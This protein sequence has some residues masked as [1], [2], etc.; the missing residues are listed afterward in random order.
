MHP[1]SSRIAI[2]GGTGKAGR[3]VVDAALARGLEVRSLARRPVV[4][5]PA[6]PGLETLAGDARDRAVIGSLIEGCG[7]VVL[8]LASRRGEEPGFEAAARS[9]VAAMEAGYVARCVVL[10]GLGIDVPGDRKGLGA[11]LQG[12]MMRALFG[13]AMKDK[14]RGVE[15][16][17]ASGLE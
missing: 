3:R 11:R 14:Q 1:D 2:I 12:A 8:S 17:M 10:V 7:S 5:I 6:R 4:A 16:V 13:P 9:L 15:A